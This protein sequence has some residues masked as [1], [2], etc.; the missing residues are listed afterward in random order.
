MYSFCTYAE[1][2]NLIIIVSGKCCQNIFVTS[3]SFSERKLHG[4]SASG[5]SFF[6]QILSRSISDQQNGGSIRDGPLMIK[7]IY[8]KLDRIN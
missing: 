4:S 2:V 6:L 3:T 8:K 7:T 5:F 1:F